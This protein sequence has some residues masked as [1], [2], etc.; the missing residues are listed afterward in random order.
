MAA[1]FASGNGAVW[2][3]G[4]TTTADRTDVST[5]GFEGVTFD[6][7]D[8]NFAAGKTLSVTFS[9]PTG[10]G[11]F[12]SANAVSGNRVISPGDVTSYSAT[13]GLAGSGLAAGEQ[14]TELGLVYTGR[15]GTVGNLSIAA[16]LDDSST[17][18]GLSPDPLNGST[19]DTLFHFDA[20]AGR[21]IT[22]FSYASSTGRGNPIDDFSFVTTVVPEPASLALLAAGGLLLGGRRRAR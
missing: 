20:P 12:S 17:I 4:T 18:T 16:T 3:S 2:N 22:G 1:A 15:N 9:R 8:L 21:F 6:T 7:A 19:E 5:N 11:Q 13:F 14:V 10:S